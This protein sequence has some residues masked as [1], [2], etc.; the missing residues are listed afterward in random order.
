[1]KKILT[2]IYLIVISNQFLFAQSEIK[3]RINHL[4]GDLPFSF[5]QTATD[6]YGNDFYID[7][8]E[9]YV[10]GIQLIHDS[11]NITDT[12][13]ILLVDASNN[14][15]YSLG[16]YDITDLE[17]IKFSIGVHEDENHNDP[18]SYPSDHP[19]YPQSPSMHW[20]W[21]AGYRFIAY[22]GMA[23][24]N[25]TFQFHSLGDKNYFE[26]ELIINTIIEEDNTKIIEL[27]ADYVQ[28][29]KDIKLSLG[30]ISHG[31]DG[32]AQTLI[33]NFAAEVFSAKETTS[34]NSLDLITEKIASVYPIP[35]FDKFINIDLKTNEVFKLN[36]FDI[37][38]KLMDTQTLNKRNNQIFFEQSGIYF[39][40]LV[41]SNGKVFTKKVNIQ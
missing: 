17:A 11:G 24:G 29:V 8:L 10:S 22:E 40:H 25:T 20:G 18:S 2:L 13:T 19:L 39:L 3:L 26:Q 5:N 1:M 41:D 16:F 14:E 28:A 6:D 30:P 12:E 34:T 23:N 9:Y 36:V 32:E 37:A 7:R 27:V 15:D 33:M 38:G 4:L 21:A 31:E 35:S